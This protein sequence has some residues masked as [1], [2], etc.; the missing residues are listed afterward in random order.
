MKIDK[1]LNLVLPLDYAGGSIWVHS[2]PISREVF[3]RHFYVI[4]KTFSSIYSGG[5]GVIAGARVAGMMLKSVATELGQWEG[6]GGV[7]NGLINEMRR[8]TNVLMP[9]P[10]GKGWATV[11]FQE[12]I[13]KKMI[14]GD[15]LSEVENALVFFMVASAMHRRAELPTVM[16]LMQ[17]WGAQTSL[18]NCTEYGRSLPTSIETVN[19]GEKE[20]RSSIP[21]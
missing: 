11:P 13:D 7:E 3:E 10:D 17:I 18:S 6:V 16:D 4:A 8:L 21:S 15:D 9:S 20:I 5:L 2:T 14:E 12:A 19:S 1:K